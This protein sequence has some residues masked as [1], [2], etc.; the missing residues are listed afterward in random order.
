MKLSHRIHMI[1]DLL[2]N[3]EVIGMVAIKTEQGIDW[4]GVTYPDE[5]SLDEAVKT[6]CGRKTEYIPVVVIDIA[7][8]KKD[9]Q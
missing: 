6:I 5:E 8:G 4:N 9:A 7:H 3:E 2:R 1:E